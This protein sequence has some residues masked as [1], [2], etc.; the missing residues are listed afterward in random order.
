MPR[1]ESFPIW[2][3]TRSQEKRHHGVWKRQERQQFLLG[4]GAETV[5]DRP[6]KPELWQGKTAGLG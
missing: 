1:C 2:D 4:A 6:H 3:S 5:V